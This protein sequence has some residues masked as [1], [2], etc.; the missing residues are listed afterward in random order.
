MKNEF[1]NKLTDKGWRSM[2]S[3][4]DREMPEQRRRRRFVWWL[5][6]LLLLPVGL[7]AWWTW[8]DTGS[9]PTP[10]A[11][12]KAP[13]VQ[14]PALQAGN[15]PIRMESTPGE[16]RSPASAIGNIPVPAKENKAMVGQP[17]HAP[18]ATE[19]RSPNTTIASKAV[20]TP[21]AMPIPAAGVDNP[22]A[23]LPQGAALL[24]DAPDAL[25]Q[26]TLAIHS[27]EKSEAKPASVAAFLPETV[28]KVAGPKRWTFGAGAGLF[29]EN[30]TAIN[31]FSAGATLNWQFARKWGLRS[32]LQYAQY[33]LA[34]NDRPVVSLD[35]YEYT[36]ATGNLLDLGTTPI[37]DPVSEVLVPVERLRKLEMPLLAY[38]QPLQRLRIFSGVTTAYTLSAQ[39]SEQNYASNGVYYADD[40][41]AR[42]NLNSLASKT[43]TRWQMG[44]QVGAGVLIGKHL[45]LSA[46]Y[47][48]GL[49]FGAG[50]KADFD[51][52]DNGSF[53]GNVADPLPTGNSS[54]SCFS[55]NGIWFF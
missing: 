30:F 11:P 34:A 50:N 12:E 8:K 32:G 2:R 15:Q 51:A 42:S 25:P 44:W 52:L 7:G 28:K 27:G 4:L 49:N 23:A 19:T 43:L 55:I 13:H 21:G 17:G 20:L 24:A 45:E 5:S 35:A 3:L 48:S 9:A 18:A 41:M 46:F 31:G 1:D 36:K 37:S 6:A 14:K 33:R 47:K 39:A 26:S 29:S 54:N 40:Q 16:T 10:T 53:T 22:M 38:W